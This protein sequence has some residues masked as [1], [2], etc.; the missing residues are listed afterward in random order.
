[1]VAE[2]TGAYDFIT[3]EI[4]EFERYKRLEEDEEEFDDWVPCETD[5]RFRDRKP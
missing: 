3:Q 2:S 4:I 1:V 5:G